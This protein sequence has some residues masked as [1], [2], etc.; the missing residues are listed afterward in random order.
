VINKTVVYGELAAFFT[1]IYIA[2]VVV[3]GIGPG[4]GSRS[5]RPLT[6]LAA[7]VMAVTF[8]AGS[9]P[10]P[11]VREPDRVREAGHPV[12]GAVGFAERMA[13]TYSMED[14]LPRMAQ[15]LAGGTGATVARVWLRVGNR[16]RV[17]ASWPRDEASPAEL[18]VEGE[19]L[20]AFPDA[21]TALAVTY[22]DEL[23]GALSVV[24]PPNEPPSPVQE[25]LIGD[26]ASQAGLV[27]RNVR[28]IEELRAYRQRLVAAQDEERRKIERNLHD[29]AQQQLVALAV[30]QWLVTLGRRDPEKAA[31]MMEELQADTTEALGNLRDLARGIYPPLLADQGLASALD[32][33][34]RKAAVPVTV[35]SDGGSAATH[36]RRRRRCTSAAWKPCRTWPSM[37]TPLGRWF[38]SSSRTASSRSLWRTR[39]TASIPHGPRWGRASR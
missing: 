31:A 30:K 17:A 13:G 38:A 28:L 32:A 14:V 10:G 5:S 21:D 19:Q 36:S 8:P 20:P 1:L 39:A 29:G 2:I 4:V 11:A 37:R 25:K 16:L 23:R 18:E 34:A 22:R 3:V 12:R 33:Q 15:I 7:V 6:I 26:L 35:E 24:M 9:R 27:L